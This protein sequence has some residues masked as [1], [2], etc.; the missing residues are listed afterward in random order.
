[1]FLGLNVLA[2]PGLECGDEKWINGSPIYENELWSGFVTGSCDIDL[3]GEAAHFDTYFKQLTEEQKNKLKV[4]E[5]P[6]EKTMNGIK[7]VRFKVIEDSGDPDEEKIEFTETVTITSD[8]KHFL[9]LVIEP[10]EIRAEGNSKYLRKLK[11]VFEIEQ[12]EGT[13]HF[14]AT[15]THHSQVA[16]PSFAPTFAFKPIVKDRV[17]KKFRKVLEK[18]AEQSKKGLLEIKTP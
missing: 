12:I 10:T 15:G 13:H 7:E 5:G 16:K 17:T 18:W 11:N 14:R 6:I 8:L 4:L 1:M 2:Y 9:R 3:I